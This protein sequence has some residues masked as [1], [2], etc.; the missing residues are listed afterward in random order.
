MDPDRPGGEELG[1]AAGF[2]TPDRRQ[3]APGCI[4]AWRGTSARNRQD[5]GEPSPAPRSTPF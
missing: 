5:R 4:Q 2:L 3:A 1:E